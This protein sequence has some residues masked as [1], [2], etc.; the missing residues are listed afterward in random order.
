MASIASLE[1]AKSANFTKLQQFLNRQEFRTLTLHVNEDAPIFP[2]STRIAV[3]ANRT[4]DFLTYAL[5]HD[6]VR[7]SYGLV[8]CTKD[9][10]VGT[11]SISAPQGSKIP[12]IRISKDPQN[13]I[14]LSFQVRMI[15]R[16]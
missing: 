13:P 8:L 15:E 16:E 6:K 11:V 7:N 14:Q 5:M 1:I 3:V 12:R 9:T 10:N 4:M 2:E